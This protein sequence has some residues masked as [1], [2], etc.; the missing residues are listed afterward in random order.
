MIH[1]IE[2]GKIHRRQLKLSSLGKAIHEILGIEVDIS[3]IK[4]GGSFD[5]GPFINL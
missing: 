4:S 5:I 3:A 1:A 2:T